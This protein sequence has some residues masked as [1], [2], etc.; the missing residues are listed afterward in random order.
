MKRAPNFKGSP[1][2]QKKQ[3]LCE[4]CLCIY[5]RNF[6]KT[7]IWI[8]NW[9]WFSEVLFEENCY[10]FLRRSRTWPAL[11]SQDYFT[12]A[13][14]TCHTLHKNLHTCI[15]PRVKARL[16]LVCTSCYLVALSYNPLRN[17]ANMI[18]QSTTL[19]DFKAQIQQSR[20][21]LPEKKAPSVRI[22][23]TKQATLLNASKNF[24]N[25]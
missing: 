3:R 16:G 25:V 20:K 17:G 22:W 23:K 9:L 8:L 5:F 1:I 21:C 11:W 24:Y 13:G 19:Q 18:P 4:M 15:Y 12:F 6:L 14:L 2:M 10:N 7:S